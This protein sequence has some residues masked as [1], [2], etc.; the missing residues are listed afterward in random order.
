MDKR[1]KRITYIAH[2]I[3]GD[4]MWNLDNIR[5]I[6]AIMLKEDKRVPFAPYLEG[7]NH[8]DD[9]NES[10]RGLGMENNRL[11][12][13]K[14]YF[15]EMIVYGDEL[16]EGVLMEIDWCKKYNIPFSFETTDCSR[17]YVMIMEAKAEK[18]IYN[19][20]LNLYKSDLTKKL[21]TT[22]SEF[23]KKHFE[24]KIKV[25]KNLIKYGDNA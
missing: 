10:D 17:K 16:S 3:N 18:A 4:V 8:L 2:P 20:A 25:L 6:Y 22:T 14:G 15:D 11:F 23:E 21:S 7:F 24:A 12:F 13:E 9:E 5:G 19:E 1:I